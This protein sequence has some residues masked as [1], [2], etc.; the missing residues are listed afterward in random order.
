MKSTVIGLKYCAFS[1]KYLLMLQG[2]Y[3]FLR[4]ISLSQEVT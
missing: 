3:C 4:N 1:F 2:L